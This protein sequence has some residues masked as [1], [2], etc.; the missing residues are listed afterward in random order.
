MDAI[1]AQELRAR[2]ADQEHWQ[3]ADAVRRGDQERIDPD[4]LELEETAD[5]LRLYGI[6]EERRRAV[7]DNAELVTTRMTKRLVDGWWE[8]RFEVERVRPLVQ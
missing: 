3:Q 4:A 6:R 8:T 1:G 7:D 5:G 2:L